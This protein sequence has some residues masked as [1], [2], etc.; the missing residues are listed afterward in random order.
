VQF[1]NIIRS[2]IVFVAQLDKNVIEKWALNDTNYYNATLIQEQCTFK[3]NG[4]K[5]SEKCKLKCITIKILNLKKTVNM[6]RFIR[7]L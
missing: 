2:V 4:T 1:S 7:L 3:A 5:I 6:F